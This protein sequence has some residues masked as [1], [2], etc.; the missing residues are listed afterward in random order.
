MDQTNYD[1]FIS[2]S[3]KDYVDEKGDVIPGN[4]VSL[5]KETFEKEGITYWFD[6]DDIYSGQNFVERIVTN[7]EASKVFVFISTSNSN[8]SKYTSREIASADELGKHIIPVRI[9]STPFN[10][11]VLFR[12]SDLDYIDYYV[13]PEK[14]LVDLVNA[15]KIHLEKLRLEERERLEE[16]RRKREIERQKQEELR[17]Q[18]EEEEKR[19]KREQE[20]LAASIRL[21]CEALNKEEVLL[22]VRRKQLL[23]QA[24]DIIEQDT[25]DSLKRHISNSSPIGQNY[26]ATMEEANTLK[27]EID[28]CNTINQELASQLAQLKNDYSNQSKELS[29]AKS[30]IE[31]L[32]KGHRTI[33][34]NTTSEKSPAITKKNKKILLFVFGGEVL[35]LL[36]Y[37]IFFGVTR[38]RTPYHHEN[39]SEYD[40]EQESDDALND[41]IQQNIGRLHVV[42]AQLKG[43]LDGYY[44]GD[45][46]SSYHLGLCF[47]NGNFLEGNCDV[48]IAGR[49]IHK[50][51]EKGYGDAQNKLGTYFLYGR[52]GFKLDYDSAVYW[53]SEAIKNGS[54]DAEYNL[55]TAYADGR[56][57]GTS[58]GQLRTADAVE[59]YTKS[60]NEG[61]AKSQLAL[62][63]YW[64]NKGDYKEAKKWFE[65]ALQGD[66]PTYEKT[67]AQFMMGQLYG[68]GKPGVE[69]NDRI[70]FDW[71]Q[72]AAL[73]GEGYLESVYYMGICY[74]NGRGV[75]QNTA[76]AKKW[77]KKAADRGHKD[78]NAKL[79]SLQ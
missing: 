67:K 41:S 7:I 8:N 71:Y 38:S 56:Y 26:A 65:Q 34:N 62:G 19:I 73:D 77:Y 14:G 49:L 58:R 10:M 76:E 32:E 17:R 74:Q 59:L 45:P 4:V 23:L 43:Y 75:A 24:E 1:V 22:D 25:K 69:R 16:E 44:A 47:E 79:R 50:S 3:R 2:Y 66:L 36:T 37:F 30:T 46:E 60:A 20:Q 70:A 27:A 68:T 39:L 9:D 42:D 63:C 11:K 72:K 5:I 35:L 33:S 21:S 64:Y 28:K 55:A 54:R 48:V 12:I 51:A 40:I 52:A 53:Y 61:Y 57:K 6:E 29:A 78:A 13:N 31:K 18:K 15:I